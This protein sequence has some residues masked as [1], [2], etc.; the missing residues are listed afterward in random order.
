MKSERRGL[1]AM[2]L[3]VGLAALAIATSPS[4]AAELAAVTAN[5]T[6]PDGAVITMWTYVDA[7]PSAAGYVCPAAPVVWDAP[8]T[9]SATAGSSLTINLKNCLSEPVSV[10][11][12]GQLKATTPVWTD[13]STGPRGANLTKRVRSFDVETA[14]GAVGSYSWNNIKEGTYLVQ[15]GTHPQVQVQMGLYGALAVTGTGYPSYEDEKVLLYSEIDP[16]LHAAVA[17]GTYGT[18]AY[19]STFAYYP[20]YYLINGAAYPD[21]ADISVTSNQDVLLRFV[22]AGLKTHSP[23]LGGGL[24]MTLYAEDGN[25]YPFA[26]QQYG[27]ELPAAKTIDAVLNV[28]A[29]GTYTLYD[30]ALGLTNGAITGGGML[31]HIQAGAPVGA[32]TAV[33]DAYTVAEDG[34][35]TTVAGDVT[36]PS[37]LDNDTGGAAAAVLVSGPSS[38]TLTGG[39]A[40]DGSF[41]YTPNA[42]FNGIDQFSYVANDGFGGPNSYPGT[43]SI[44][45]TAGN[46]A[47]V[48]ADNAYSVVAGAILN[49][50]APGVLGNDIDIDGDTLSAVL[51]T[52]ATAGTLTLYADGGLDFDASLLSAGTIATFTYL[53]ND[54]TVNSATAATATI[55]VVAPVNDAPVAG[56]DS[57]STPRN[58]SVAISVLQNDTDDGTINVASVDLNP[59]LAGQQTSVT[60][61]RG[62]YASVNLATGVVTYTP[63]NAGFRGTDTFTYTVKDTLGATSN[64]A[65]VRVN[66]VK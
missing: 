2:R 49:V 1:R 55:T 21:T 63:P 14:A 9:L 46:D 43:V 5:A 16:A 31:T 28:G 15:S 13:G 60:C 42:N 17:G 22:N 29:D 30:R 37:V 23:A 45:V 41:I 12:P 62:G 51:N 6:M 35:L 66:V 57:A 53:A 10:F 24:Y 44:T 47:P 65:T 4:F 40:A 25:L 59:G 52:D 8:Q 33:A 32:P 58:T 38:G 19:P 39:L 3:A 26:T 48:A 11:I 18:A 50:A 7:S 64:V 27:L 36:F 34:T 54:G 56:D 61:S 20:Q